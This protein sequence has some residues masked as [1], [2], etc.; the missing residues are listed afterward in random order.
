MASTSQEN[1]QENIQLIM[2]ITKIQNYYEI[3]TTTS[4][5]TVTNWLIDDSDYG[6]LMT[7]IEHSKV[8]NFELNSYGMKQDIS[9]PLRQRTSDPEIYYLEIGDWKIPI[10]RD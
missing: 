9:Y 10:V 6:K 4:N 3:Q 1:V 8:N 5:N 7:A 2:K